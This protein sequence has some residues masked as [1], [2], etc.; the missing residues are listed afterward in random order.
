M[1]SK[2]IFNKIQKV[3]NQMEFAYFFGLLPTTKIIWL[4]VL[5]WSRQQWA[6]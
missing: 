2:N 3:S 5:S 6:F 4:Q 1:V